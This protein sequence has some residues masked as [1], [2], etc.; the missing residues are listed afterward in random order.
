MKPWFIFNA[1]KGSAVAE[2]R[3]V[4]IIGGWIDEYWGQGGGSGVITAKSFLDQLAKLEDGVKTIRLSINSPGGDV[5]AGLAMANALR[6]QQVSKGRA[7]EVSVDGLAA[8]AATL[9]MMAGSTIRVADN[10]LVMIHDPWSMAIGNAAELRKM[11]EE[12]DTIRDA[13]VATYQWHSPMSAEGLRGLMAAETWL[14]ADQAIAAG[15][16]TEKAEGLKAAAL[17]DPR[18]V[19]ALKVPEAFRARVDAL[20]APP[21]TEPPKPEPAAAADVLRLC[22]EGECLDLA[23]GLIAA[24]ATLETVTAKV[25]EAKAAKQAAADRAADIRAACKLV[26]LE[27][28]AD[29]YVAGGMPLDQVRAQLTRMT[30]H[31]DA[32]V[33]IDGRLAPDHRAAGGR[34]ALNIA[35][36]YAARRPK[37]KE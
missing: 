37:Q 29:S 18:G 17:L 5:F 7:V 20:L 22:R 8:S 1:A 24:A 6:E 14:D 28:L 27:D 11:A 2:I 13:I 21:V 16:A 23:E 19:K 33:E 25:G 10:G 3:I 30:A 15:L 32:K 9:P 34:E 26:N 36:I 4:D 31:L 35:E 12:L